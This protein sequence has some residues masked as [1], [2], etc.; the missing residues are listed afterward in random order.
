MLAS[1]IAPSAADSSSSC[2][3][4]AE[5][6]HF[7]PATSARISSIAQTSISAS[8]KDQFER[9]IGPMD[10][11]HIFFNEPDCSEVLG[12]KFTAAKELVANQHAFPK[13]RRSVGVQV[14]QNAGRRPE[15]N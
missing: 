15:A 4:I 5:L 6:L 13:N 11:E 3:S 10:F 1:S 14:P 2:S 9:P 7:V 12:M 8:T